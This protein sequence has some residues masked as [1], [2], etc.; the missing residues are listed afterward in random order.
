MGLPIYVRF[1]APSQA[2]FDPLAT[3][4]TRP[5]HCEWTPDEQAQWTRNY[6]LMALAKPFVRG[7]LWANWA[8]F[9]PHEFPHSG[10]LDL[11]RRFKP[12]VEALCELRRSY[13]L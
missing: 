9:Q 13:L 12:V 4:K 3:G 5:V 6:F 8:D 2:L 11:T 1:S 7:F 10:L